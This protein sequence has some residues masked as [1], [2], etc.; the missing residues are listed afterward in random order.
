[1]KRAKRWHV[2][3]E[4]L[5]PLKE[6]RQVG[7]ALSPDEKARLLQVSATNP[8]WQTVRCAAILALNTTMRG[9]ELKSLR[10]RD[11]NLIDRTLTIQKSKTEAGERVIP[12]NAEAMGVIAE[13]LKRAE[14][15][16]GANLNNY[17]FP[18]CENGHID[19]T[20]HQTT[21]RTA[22]RRLTRA[23]NCPACDKLQDP[24]KV[25]CN[26]ECKAD[27]SKVKGPTAGL[28]FHDLRH[29]AITELAESQASDQTIMA[30]AGHVSLKMLKHYSHVRIDA[31]REA[32]EALSRRSEGGYGTK[33]DTNAPAAAKPTPQVIEINGRPG[34]TRTSD[35]FRVNLPRIQKRRT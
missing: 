3:G 8:D 4:G 14:T 29:H 6:K 12:L 23:I 33:D 9:C 11:V 21:W 26:E 34:R 35:L 19:P 16:D 30:I 15:F 32:L 13:L 27:I 28:R 18:A 7:R 1:M 17:V 20:R 10:W 2:V 25:C 24:G 5:R 22:W 31:M